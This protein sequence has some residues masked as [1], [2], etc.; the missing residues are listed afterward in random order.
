[1]RNEQPPFREIRL[2]YIGGML[3]V[4]L[5]IIAIF[6]T[7]GFTVSPTGLATGQQ[8]CTDDD[9]GF[10]PDVKG[11]VR[12]V[13]SEGRSQESADTC[14]EDGKSVFEK[15]CGADN[16]A[17]SQRVDCQGGACKDG[18]CTTAQPAGQAT[19]GTACWRND[20]GTPGTF[21][22]SRGRLGVL[23][24]DGRCYSSLNYAEELRCCNDSDCPSYKPVCSGDGKCVEG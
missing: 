8:T 21:D 16:T 5:V 1:M 7:A 14:S 6:L 24:L 18:A 12:Y 23:G 19:C 3:S 15:T 4:A 20:D 11:V 13:D 10:N 22:S 2:A 17:V 9:G